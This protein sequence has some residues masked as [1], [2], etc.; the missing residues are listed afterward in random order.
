MLAKPEMM[1]RR[2][3][4]KPKTTEDIAFIIEFHGRRF[5]KNGL[6]PRKK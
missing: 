4:G 6:F 5:V 3:K 2:G 1:R